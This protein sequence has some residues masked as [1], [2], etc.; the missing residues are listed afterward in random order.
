[1]LT[2]V[3]LIHVNTR[4]LNILKLEYVRY[5]ELMKEREGL[6]RLKITLK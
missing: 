1:M 6:R 3:K 5:F 4:F 2:L